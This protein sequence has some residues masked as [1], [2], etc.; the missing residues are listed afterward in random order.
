MPRSFSVHHRSS[1][2]AYLLLS[3]SHFAGYSSSLFRTCSEDV[4]LAAFD[5]SHRRGTPGRTFSDRWGRVIDLLQTRDHNLPRR[6]RCFCSCRHVFLG[7]L[8]CRSSRHCQ[9]LD[10]LLIVLLHTAI[11][12]LCL[13]STRG[14]FDGSSAANTNFPFH[15]TTYVVG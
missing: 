9:L 3:R 10:E 12:V 15:F 5:R 8:V 7:S 6:A 4:F 1:H 2:P 14:C 11:F 13:P